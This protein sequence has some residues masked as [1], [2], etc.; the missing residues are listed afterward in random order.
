MPSTRCA[1]P[2]LSPFSQGRPD[3]RSGISLSLTD[4][5]YWSVLQR[6]QVRLVAEMLLEKETITNSD[7]AG[8]IGKRPHGSNKE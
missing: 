1:E 3:S 4:L 5:C 6:A 8:L 7:V 2:Y